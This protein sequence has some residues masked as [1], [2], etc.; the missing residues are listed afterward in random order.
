VA[1][2]VVGTQIGYG[3]WGKETRLSRIIGEGCS[4]GSKMIPREIRR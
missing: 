3:G 2:P 4:Y 1:K